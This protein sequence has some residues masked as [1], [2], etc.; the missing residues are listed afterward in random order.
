MSFASL[1]GVCADAATF[2]TRQSTTVWS[3]PNKPDAL[4]AGW[5]SPDKEPPTPWLRGLL[6]KDL[7][8][9]ES[10]TKTFNQT[11]RAVSSSGTLIRRQKGRC[12]AS[13]RRSDFIAV[14]N[15]SVPC[16]ERLTVFFSGE[17]ACFCSHSEHMGI[18]YSICWGCG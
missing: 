5:S 12:M 1:K 11:I 3:T 4:Q 17:D 18:A 15:L 14:A 9:I 7:S 2:A 6:M 10:W 13:D 8:T 16:P